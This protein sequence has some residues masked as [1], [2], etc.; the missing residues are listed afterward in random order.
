MV[1]E[2]AS[3][4]SS[5]FSPDSKN[6]VHSRSSRLRSVQFRH[7]DEDP[8]VSK[9]D[10]EEKA[11]W[12]LMTISSQTVQKNRLLILPSYCRQPVSETLVLSAACISVL[13]RQGKEKSEKRRKEM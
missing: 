5:L 4:V 11:E 2:R 9:T 8:F 12:R 1:E 6:E 7:I 10:T 13:L 3:S